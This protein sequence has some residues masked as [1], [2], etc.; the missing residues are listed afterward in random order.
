MIDIHDKHDKNSDDFV[1]ILKGDFMHRIDT[2]IVANFF[3]WNGRLNRLRYIKRGFAIAGVCLVFYLLVGILAVLGSDNPDEMT[4]AIIAL[5][6][7][8]LLLCLPLTVSNYM[9]MIRR[10][11]DLD[12]SGFFCLLSLIPLINVG[13]SIYLLAKKGTPGENTYDPD[14]LGPV[15]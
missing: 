15:Q 3:Q 9:L 6:G 5:Y 12:L 4:G 1:L 2:G 10:L 7:F 13:F 8:F 11:H 14:P